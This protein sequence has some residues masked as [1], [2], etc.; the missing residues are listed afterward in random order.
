[1]ADEEIERCAELYTA[2]GKL[3][4]H[5]LTFEQFYVQLDDPRKFRD[6][7]ITDNVF[8]KHHKNTIKL[9]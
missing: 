9:I 3:K 7:A 6:W 5:R 4:P 1:M 2:I 8:A